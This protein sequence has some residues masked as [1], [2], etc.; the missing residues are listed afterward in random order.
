[1]IVMKDKLEKTGH[2]KLYYRAKTAMVCSLCL[3][4]F[5]G[6]AAI[7]VG[8]SYQLARAEAYEERQNVSSSVS[9][10]ETEEN[11][12]SYQE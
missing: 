3:I 2:K 10:S 8:I 4:A 7:P 11:L 6:L 5:C 9:T 12:L 1:M